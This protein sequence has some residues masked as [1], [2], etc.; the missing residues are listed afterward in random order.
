[1]SYREVRKK[2]NYMVDLHKKNLLTL[3]NKSVRKDEKFK[4]ELLRVAFIALIVGGTVAFLLNN[5]S[6]RE[7]L[8]LTPIGQNYRN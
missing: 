5:D 6:V 2:E 1:M 7:N 4:Y 3:G 8:N